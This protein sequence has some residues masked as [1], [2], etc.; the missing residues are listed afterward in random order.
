MNDD[1]ED[2]LKTHYGMNSSSLSESRVDAI[3]A[4]CEPA[5]QISLWKR[6]AYAGFGS[7]V[8]AVLVLCAVVGSRPQSPAVPLVEN[9]QHQEP[10][11]GP[12]NEPQNGSQHERPTDGGSVTVAELQQPERFQLIAV[13][14]HSDPCGRCRKI[15]PVFADL[16]NEFSDDPVLFLTFDLTSED[17]RRQAERLSRSFGIEHVFDKHRYTGVIVLATPDGEVWDIVDSDADTALAVEVVS[18]NLISG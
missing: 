5:R 7:A 8:A 16:Q 15:A 14:I 1:I 11:N 17:S 3:L 2:A 4:F 18:R 13:K 6:R 12:Q 9:K 10:Q